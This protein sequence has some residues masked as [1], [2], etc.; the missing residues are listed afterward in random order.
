MEKKRIK[1]DGR[2]LFVIQTTSEKLVKSSYIKALT[3]ESIILRNNVHIE[4]EH[5]NNIYKLLEILEFIEQYE[6]NEI[7][8]SFIIEWSTF[9]LEV[10]ASEIEEKM[11]NS[12]LLYDRNR[13]PFALKMMEKRYDCNNGITWIDIEN[14]LNEFCRIN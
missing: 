2:K 6:K 10:Y 3:S 8:S 7:N 1:V 4:Y 13:F 5:I 12:K 11:N 9:D 14:H